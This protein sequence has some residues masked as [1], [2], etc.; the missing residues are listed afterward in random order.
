MLGTLDWVLCTLHYGIPFVLLLLLFLFLYAASATSF[1]LPP[2]HISDVPSSSHRLARRSPAEDARLADLK[3]QGG[4]LHRDLLLCQATYVTP[5]RLCQD[6]QRPVNLQVVH[7]LGRPSE[8]LQQLALLGLLMRPSFCLPA[9]LQA[10]FRVIGL[11]LFL[12]PAHEPLHILRKAP[13]NE[14]GRPLSQHTELP[15]GSASLLAG[16]QLVQDPNDLST[17][18]GAEAEAVQELLPPP[19]GQ[20][21]LMQLFQVISA[22][23]APGRL[24]LLLR[25]EQ[26]LTELLRVHRELRA[27]RPIKS[28]F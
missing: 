3:R 25:E 23:Q 10:L 22:E 11:H 16:L 12:I 4:S 24:L 13:D 28:E 9:L 26:G 19:Q 21:A 7:F 18:L 27:G 1:G 14:I 20:A 15:Q 8:A 5:H 17:L 6:L 2:S